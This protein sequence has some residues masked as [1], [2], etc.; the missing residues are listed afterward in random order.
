MSDIHDRLSDIAAMCSDL[1]NTRNELTMAK[2][3]IWVL[4]KTHGINNEALLLHTDFAR[5]DG[6]SSLEIEK[7]PDGDVILRARQ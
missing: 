5:M 4:V 3:I 2:R 7:K 1:Q 6:G